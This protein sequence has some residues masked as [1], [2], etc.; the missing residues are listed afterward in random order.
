MDERKSAET[1]SVVEGLFI[2]T[3]PG[4]QREILGRSVARESKKTRRISPL[5]FRSPFCMAETNF[6][7]FKGKYCGFVKTK[8]V[9]KLCFVKDGAY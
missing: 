6:D 7:V 8:G 2:L 3:L 4:V 1:P 5:F 9:H